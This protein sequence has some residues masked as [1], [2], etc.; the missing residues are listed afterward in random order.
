MKR[1][2]KGEQG[3]EVEILSPAVAISEDT[4]DYVAPIEGAVEWLLTE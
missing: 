4:N 3:N 2:N 1:I